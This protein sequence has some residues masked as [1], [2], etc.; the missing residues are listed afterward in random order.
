MKITSKA[1]GN[2]PNG[3]Q[4]ELFTLSNDKGV[5]IKITNYGA[6]ITSIETPDKKGNT[7]INIQQN[8]F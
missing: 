1:F 7:S 6:I 8:K 2:L 4:A 5:V 3:T